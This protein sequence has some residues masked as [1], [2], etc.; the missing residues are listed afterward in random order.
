MAQVT[1]IAPADADGKIIGAPVR[2]P[3]VIHYPAKAIGLCAGFINA[4]Y[5]TT[6]EVYPDGP[7][8]TDAICNAA[9]VAAV[10]AGLDFAL[11]QGASG[12]PTSMS[13]M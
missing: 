11:A 2:Q 8:I 6:T 13:S 1:H 4:R 10:R 5:T 7:E 12:S 9:Q 3:G